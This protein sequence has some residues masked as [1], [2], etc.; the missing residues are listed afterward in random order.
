MFFT[1]TDF[2]AILYEKSKKEQPKLFFLWW[3]L[4]GSNR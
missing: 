2:G 3:S 4:T 1:Y